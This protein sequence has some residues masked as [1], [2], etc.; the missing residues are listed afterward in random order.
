MPW[1]EESMTCSDR[2]KGH[3]WHTGPHGEAPGSIS[4]LTQVPGAAR[5]TALIVFSEGQASV[6]L[7][8]LNDSRLWGG[9]AVPGCLIPGPGAM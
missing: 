5:A 6:G 3:P 9:G 4:K 7:A 2:K 1:E 8:S